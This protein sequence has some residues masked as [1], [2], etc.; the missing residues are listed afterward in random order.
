MCFCSIGCVV[1]RSPLPTP[2]DDLPTLPSHT[3]G[4]PSHIL[5]PSYHITMQHS[6]ICRSWGVRNRSKYEGLFDTLSMVT[7]LFRAWLGEK[8]RFQP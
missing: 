1:V 6:A 5:T 4:P 8:A 3:L 7:T 2:Q